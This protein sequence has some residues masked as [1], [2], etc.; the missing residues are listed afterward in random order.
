VSTRM[1]RLRPLI[2][3]TRCSPKDQAKTLFLNGTVHDYLKLWNWDGGVRPS[4]L[5]RQILRPRRSA[6]RRCSGFHIG[7]ALQRIKRPVNHVRFIRLKNFPD[8]LLAPEKTA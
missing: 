8:R 1:C 4:C 2:S 7:R 3:C 5:R 6:A